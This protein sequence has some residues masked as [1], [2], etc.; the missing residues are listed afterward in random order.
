M[1]DWSK[2]KSYQWQARISP[3]TMPS[4]TREE[5]ISWLIWNDPNGVYRDEQSLQEFGQ[6]ITKDEALEIALRQIS[7]Y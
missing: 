3:T 5:L 7:G 2:N 6:I 1:E 4:L